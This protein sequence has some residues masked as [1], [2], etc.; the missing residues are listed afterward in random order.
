MEFDNGGKV[1]VEINIAVCADSSAK[2]GVVRRFQEDMASIGLTVVV[3]EMTWDNYIKALEEG[4]IAISNTGEQTVTLDM[5]Y[6]EVKLRANFDLTELLQPRKE[7][8]EMTNIN[9]SRSTDATVVDRIERYL[10]ASNAARPGAYYEFCQYL[11]K[12]SASLITIGFE[13][14]Q[15]ITRRGVCKGVE[16]NAGNPLYNFPNWTIDLKND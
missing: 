6:G 13:K 15:I 1:P 16:P 12:T 8:N 14:Q 9:F 2:A 11:T 5:Y 7:S 10:S 3:H 4:E